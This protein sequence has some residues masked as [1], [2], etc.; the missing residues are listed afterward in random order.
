MHVGVGRV[1]HAIEPPVDEA[2][3]P[4]SHGLD[5]R[6]LLLRD[7]PVETPRCAAE[8]DACTSRQGLRDRA[9]PRPALQR[10]L[11]LGRQLEGLDRPAYPSFSHRHARTTGDEPMDSN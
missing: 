7:L 9:P 6:P 2:L 8:Y 10:L 11:L 5:R 4:F 3:T 1:R